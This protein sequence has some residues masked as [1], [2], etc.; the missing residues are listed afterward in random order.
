ML[1]FLNSTLFS[2]YLNVRSTICKP[3][4][5]YLKLISV[6]FLN[7]VFPYCILFYIEIQAFCNTFSR[8]LYQQIVL[9]TISYYFISLLHQHLIVQTKN[10]PDPN[11]DYGCSVLQ[12]KEEHLYPITGMLSMEQNICCVIC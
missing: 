4:F 5:S 8:I 3:A 12:W 9:A 2:H 6:F 7:R 11:R 1:S 10:T